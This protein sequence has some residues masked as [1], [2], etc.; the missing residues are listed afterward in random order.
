MNCIGFANVM[1]NA[2]IIN[3]FN[4]DNIN[5]PKIKIQHRQIM[6]TITNR[7]LK[8][9]PILKIPIVACKTFYTVITFSNIDSFT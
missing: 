5:M 2:T 3:T 6:T 4:S 1:N 7:I 8:F 9:E